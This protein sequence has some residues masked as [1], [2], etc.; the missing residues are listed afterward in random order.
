L[1]F[2]W[3]RNGQK[4]CDKY[5]LKSDCE[6]YKRCLINHDQ[7]LLLYERIQND[8]EVRSLTKLISILALEI[9]FR[10]FV[11]KELTSSSK[12]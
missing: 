2:D 5:I 9:W 12:L 11:T 7:I 4:I 1:L 8:G 3:K 6:I 10:I